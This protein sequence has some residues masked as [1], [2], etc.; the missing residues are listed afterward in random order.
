MAELGNDLFD[1]LQIMSPEELNSAVKANEDNDEETGTTA[2]AEFTLEP[3]ETEKGEGRS[4]KAD[5]FFV[6]SC[7]ETQAG[8]PELNSTTKVK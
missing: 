8:V 3:V 7:R 2:E 1:G 5:D 4:R 6:G